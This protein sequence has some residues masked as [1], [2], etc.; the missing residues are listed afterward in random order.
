MWGLPTIAFEKQVSAMTGLDEHLGLY[1][2]PLNEPCSRTLGIHLELKQS[3]SKAI[4]LKSRRG[5]CRSV[6][7]RKFRRDLGEREAR[8]EKRKPERYSWRR[9]V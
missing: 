1:S 5:H 8:E 3:W 7:H 2:K 4:P 6:I 9:N